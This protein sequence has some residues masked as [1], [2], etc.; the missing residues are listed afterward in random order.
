MFAFARTKADMRNVDVRHQARAE[1]LVISS[2][3]LRGLATIVP[4]LIAL[5]HS[6]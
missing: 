3:P 1:F 2:L 5:H 4:I 6:K